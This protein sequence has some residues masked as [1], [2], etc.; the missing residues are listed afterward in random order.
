MRMNRNSAVFGTC[1]FMARC[2]FTGRRRVVGE[3]FQES[4]SG[5]W[6]SGC[7]FVVGLVFVS[8]LASYKNVIATFKCVSGTLS[9]IKFLR[10]RVSI[11]APVVECT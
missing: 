3:R 8:L 4:T 11:D 9:A 6:S 7:L 2:V 10:R 1:V 5:D